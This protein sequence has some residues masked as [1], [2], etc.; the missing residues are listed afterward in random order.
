MRQPDDWPKR[1]L[2]NKRYDLNEGEGTRIWAKCRERAGD[3]AALG[4]ASDGLVARDGAA[5]YGEPQLIQPRL[6]Q[7]AFRVAVTD[8][9]DRA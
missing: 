3:L 1:N 5:R 7:G 6:G 4:E 2:T 9:Y 8:A